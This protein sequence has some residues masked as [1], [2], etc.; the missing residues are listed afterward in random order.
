MFRPRH[1]HKL[2]TILITRST[3]T[4]KT[5]KGID[6]LCPSSAST[7]VTSSLQH[8]STARGRTKSYDHDGRK[9]YKERRTYEKP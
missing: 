8:R 2:T 6:L 3:K 1:C 9:K 4:M 7:A 5:M